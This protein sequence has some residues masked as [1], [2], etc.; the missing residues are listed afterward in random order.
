MS[1]TVLRVQNNEHCRYSISSGNEIN[2]Q[3]GF[4]KNICEYII[5]IQVS[6]PEGQK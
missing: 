6:I 3:Q 2:P 4:Q 5:E 1:M